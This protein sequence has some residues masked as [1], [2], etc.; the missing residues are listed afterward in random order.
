MQLITHLRTYKESLVKT[1]LPNILDYAKT[2]PTKDPTKHKTAF[3]FLQGCMKHCEENSKSNNIDAYKYWISLHQNSLLKLHDMKINEM[4]MPMQMGS[5]HLTLEKA[6]M[7]DD[8]LLAFTWILDMDWRM[9]KYYP[10]NLA[11]TLE[12]KDGFKAEYVCIPRYDK[13]QEKFWR[14]PSLSILDAEEISLLNRGNVMLE[15]FRRMAEMKKGK[16]PIRIY[17]VKTPSYL[18]DEIDIINSIDYVKDW[19][20]PLFGVTNENGT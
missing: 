8:P 12:Y 18:Y 16:G 14:N 1:H 6:R 3:D 13:A 20:L 19:T 4:V 9:F 10:Y 7:F 2:L 11:F 5:K 15:D 17:S